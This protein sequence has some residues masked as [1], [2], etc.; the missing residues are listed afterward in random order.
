MEERED[1]STTSFVKE[2]YY[3]RLCNERMGVIVIII[4]EYTEYA[5]YFVGGLV[6]NYKTQI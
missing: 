1:I 4:I 6:G 5:V 3:G 2:F